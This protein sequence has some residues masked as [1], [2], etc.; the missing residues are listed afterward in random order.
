MLSP[1]T[2]DYVPCSYKDEIDSFTNNGMKKMWISDYY[3]L[4]KN[5]ESM[6]KGLMRSPVAFGTYISDNLYAYSGGLYDDSLCA[7]RGMAHAMLL[8]G[9]TGIVGYT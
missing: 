5:E 1:Y 3:P 9:Y 2:A 4:G 6:L 7:S 8:V